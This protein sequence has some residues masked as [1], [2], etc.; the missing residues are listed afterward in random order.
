MST[1]EVVV[2]LYFN[3]IVDNQYLA[4]RSTQQPSVNGIP[5]VVCK[6]SMS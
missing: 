6:E 4:C 1:N 2:E 3:N 5:M